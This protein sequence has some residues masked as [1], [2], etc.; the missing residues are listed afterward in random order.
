MLVD[1]PDLTGMSQPEL[2]ELFGRGHVD[3]IPTG[4]AAGTAIVMPGTRVS[5][6][7]AKLIRFAAWQGK[8]FDADGR[9]LANKVSP[10]RIRAIRADVYQGRSWFDGEECIVLD[11]SSTSLV[12]RWI[13]DEIRE[14]TPSRFLGV[15]YWRKRRFG[16]FLLEFVD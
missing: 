11:Y 15:V 3:R 4:D 10:F 5:P 16:N 13:R 8:V 1:V 12:A 7:L 14:L 2:D 9:E 6:V